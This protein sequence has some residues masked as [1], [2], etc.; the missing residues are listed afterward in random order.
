MVLTIILV[1]FRVLPGISASNNIEFILSLIF[2]SGILLYFFLSLSVFDAPFSAIA[3][4]Y[5]SIKSNPE[6]AKH[7]A[8]EM[9]ISLLL[10]VVSFVLLTIDKYMQMMLNIILLIIVG[11]IGLLG[12]KDKKENKEK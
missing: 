9:A 7:Y 8:I 12:D 4:I 10:G 11:I 5:Y 3:L 6:K 1:K 2:S